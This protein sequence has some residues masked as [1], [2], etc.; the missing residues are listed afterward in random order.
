MELLANFATEN[1]MKENFLI[2]VNKTCQRMTND[3]PTSILFYYAPSG[4]M[5]LL[6]PEMFG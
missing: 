3:T 5:S 2:Q 6:S 1:R 4:R